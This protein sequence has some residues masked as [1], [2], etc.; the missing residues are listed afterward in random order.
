MPEPDAICLACAWM[1]TDGSPI[2]RDGIL[3]CPKCGGPI[4]SLCDKPAI[5][6]DSP[7][8]PNADTACRRTV[9]NWRS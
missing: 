1:D 2:L 7:Y 4:E 9:H 8:D 6:I 3:V 5:V